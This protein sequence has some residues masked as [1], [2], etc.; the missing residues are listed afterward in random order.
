LPGS[1]KFLAPLSTELDY[2]QDPPSWCGLISSSVAASNEVLNVNVPHNL[3]ILQQRWK[4]TDAS[5]IGHRVYID[6]GKKEA[7]INFLKNWAAA[8]GKPISLK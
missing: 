8:R 2:T 6:K 5:H 1:I 4:E 3:A 7:A